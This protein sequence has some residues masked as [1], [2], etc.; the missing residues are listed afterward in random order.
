MLRSGVAAPKTAEQA[1]RGNSD[2]A[3]DWI[4]LVTGYDLQAVRKI[5]GRLSVDANATVQTHSLALSMARGDVGAS[6][7]S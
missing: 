2:Q 6:T 3:A 4:V 1:I 5:A 7:R